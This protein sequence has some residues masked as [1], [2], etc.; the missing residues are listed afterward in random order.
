MTE[1]PIDQLVA[2]H[3]AQ[4]NQAVSEQF[5]GRRVY[6]E[7]IFLKADLVQPLDDYIREEIEHLKNQRSASKLVVMLETGGGYLEVTERIA[8]IFRK[9]YRRVEFFVPNYAYSA[10]T[11]LVMSGDEIH[12]DY[13]SVLGPIDPQITFGGNT[14]VSSVGYLATF[15]KLIE[16]INK[17]TDINKVRAEMAQLDK[18]DP[19]ILSDIEQSIEYS[20]S[21]LKEWLPKYKF[22]DWKQTERTKKKVGA[23]K[24]IERAEE[25]AEILGDV[26]RWHSHGRGISLQVLKSEEI[27][28]QVNDYGKKPRNGSRSKK[29]P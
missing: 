6:A 21:L 28:L 23:K 19:A 15:Y 1:S 27:K 17:E 22:K 2:S 20:R 12:M 26:T 25:I 7:V 5:S 4:L 10:G 3:L 11:I 8:R 13:H 29:L 24:R 9:H 18:F 14:Q 16:E